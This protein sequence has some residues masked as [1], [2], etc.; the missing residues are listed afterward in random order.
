MSAVQ[1]ER[2]P[3]PV[4]E[5]VF[6]AR[7]ARVGVL[8]LILADAIMMIAA[9]ASYGYLKALNTEAT[10]RPAGEHAPSPA[11]G[12]VVALL[13]AAGAV[14]YRA[15]VVPGA[16]T[17]EAG[18]RVRGGL[19]LVLGLVTVAL[20]VQ[21]WLM[22][23]GLSYAV[24]VHGYASMVILLA[25]LHLVHLALTAVAT[26]LLFGR[27]ARGLLIGR[28]YLVEAAGYWWYYVAVLG[29]LVWVLGALA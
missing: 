28:G 26:L 27:T 14:A 18:G 20:A 17:R 29:I 3:Q 5:E 16:G 1:A 13:V 2:H 22:A 7:R 15:M 10:F 6:R 24:P 25:G 8:L 21:C 9:F 19:A 12:L 23:A 11:G 4:S